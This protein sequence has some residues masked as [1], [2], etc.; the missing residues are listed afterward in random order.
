MRGTHPAHL[1]ADTPEGIIPA[2]AGNTISSGI[3][4]PLLRDHPRVCGEHP[5][6]ESP[7]P[8]C[9]GSSPR[10]RGTP[11]FPPNRSRRPGIIPAYAGNTLFFAR[12]FRM[13]WDHPRVCGEHRYCSDALLRTAGS[14]PRMRG[15]RR[16]IGNALGY[17]GIIPAY[18]GNTCQRRLRPPSPWDHPRVCG[19]HESKDRKEVLEEGS[20][21][22]MRGT[23]CE[24]VLAG[25]QHGII[26]AYAGNT[27]G[28]C[29]SVPLGRDH[30]RVCGEHTVKRLGAGFKPGSSPRMR[31]TPTCRNL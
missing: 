30:P 11:H 22:R 1:I 23:L 29:G 17:T 3:P 10:M 20:S 27:L 25:F 28:C 24:D 5:S 18:A 21:P 14:S 19:E 13:H 4:Y 16:K 12:I 8:N 9:L 2:Y 15:T 7:L 6:T 26:P 31:G